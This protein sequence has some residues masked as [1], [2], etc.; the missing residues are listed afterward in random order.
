MAWHLIYYSPK[1][2]ALIEA[3]PAGVRACF[4]H[5]AQ[6]MAVHGPDLGMP[7]TRAMG[8]GLFEVRAKGRE[9]IGRAFYCTVTGQRIVILHAFIKKTEQT[10]SRELE[11]ARARLREIK[12]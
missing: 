5:I 1:V 4:M 2:A 8:G 3:W 10:P 6:T 7:H 9:G 12:T 11:T